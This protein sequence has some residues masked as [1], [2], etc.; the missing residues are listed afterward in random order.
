MSESGM[1]AQQDRTE[2][3]VSSKAEKARVIA[4]FMS[5]A[6]E[7]AMGELLKA[8]SG[9][10][11]RFKLFEH[12]QAGTAKLLVV[13]G[14]LDEALAGDGLADFLG[15][16]DENEFQIVPEQGLQTREASRRAVIFRFCELWS[17]SL[18]SSWESMYAITLQKSARCWFA[19]KRLR[20][21]RYENIALV[22]GLGRFGLESVLKRLCGELDITNLADCAL[23]TNARLSE[24]TWMNAQ[25]KQRFRNFQKHYAMPVPGIFSRASSAQGFSRTTSLH[26]FNR[27]ASAHIPSSEDAP[28]RALSVVESVD[29]STCAASWSKPK[30]LFGGAAAVQKAN[31]IAHSSAAPEQ[32]AMFSR[33]QSGPISRVTSLPNTSISRTPS[34][35]AKNAAGSI[36]FQRALSADRADGSKDIIL[37]KMFKIEET[38]KMQNS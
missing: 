14:R 38:A 22:D 20:K 17:T 35:P 6:D 1:D 21:R 5:A 13:K 28:Q 16:A 29:P 27:V 31:L 26:S 32:Q 3:H 11:W 36:L 25:T 2:A 4:S 33:A 9:S 12:V 18:Q 19:R 15:S 37:D 24:L 10:K 7:L 23:V 8:I 30:I 34:G